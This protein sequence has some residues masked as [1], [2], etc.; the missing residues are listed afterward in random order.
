M[1]GGGGRIVM[2]IQ[3]LALKMSN[4]KSENASIY[5]KSWSK[6]K[7]LN[8]VCGPNTVRF[9]STSC[10]SRPRKLCFLTKHCLKM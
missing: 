4:L 8:T 1:E 9:F 6:G 5:E 3:H 2:Y 10:F 7:V